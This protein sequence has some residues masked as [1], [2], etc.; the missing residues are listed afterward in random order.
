MREPLEHGYFVA[1]RP[2][3]SGNGGPRRSA[4]DDG[5]LDFVLATHEATNASP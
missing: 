3:V 4:T 5:N 1:Q 2:Q